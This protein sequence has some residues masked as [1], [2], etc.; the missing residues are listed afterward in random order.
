MSLLQALRVS[1]G[2]SCQ[3][4]VHHLFCH[5]LAVVLNVLDVVARFKRSIVPS[6]DRAFAVIHFHLISSSGMMVMIEYVL[7]LK[8]W[9]YLIIVWH[10]LDTT[11]EKAVRPILH[12]SAL[13][14]VLEKNKEPCLLWEDVCCWSSAN[15]SFGYCM[16]VHGFL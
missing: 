7:Y 6:W 1:A 3:E 10:V 9:R 13:W 15:H 14:N 11:A 2:S 12:C 16:N 5:W 8:C 4:A